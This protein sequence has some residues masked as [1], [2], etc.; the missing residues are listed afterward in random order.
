MTVLDR[1][2]LSILV[3]EESGDRA[4][5][6]RGELALMLPAAATASADVSVIGEGKIPD[7]DAI[8]VDGGESAR[9]TTELLRVLRAR[10][11]GGPLIVLTP[12]PDDPL[13]RSTMDAFGIVWVA[14][15]RADESPGELVAA[16]TSAL[17][18]DTDLAATLRQARRVFAAG[19]AT[20]SLQHAINNPLAALLAEA[21]LLQMEELQ[22]EHRESVDR[23]VELCRRVVGLVRRLDV[24]A[25]SERD[26]AH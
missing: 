10:G 4:G 15:A 17:G 6:L 13:L 3:L 25:V 23:I 12:V 2:D 19:H 8:L 18:A 11:F 20:L 9:G 7:A 5:V 24:L 16:L 21:Q 14:R 26:E 1:N 22:G